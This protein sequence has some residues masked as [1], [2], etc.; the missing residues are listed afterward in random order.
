[1][2]VAWRTILVLGV[3]LVACACAANTGKGGLLRRSAKAQNLLVGDTQPALVGE[4]KVPA[5][6]S[7][8]DSLSSY[9]STEKVAEDDVIEHIEQAGRAKRSAEE[10]A[11]RIERARQAML[12]R[13]R[14][15]L[16][17]KRWLKENAAK[18]AASTRERRLK[19]GEKHHRKMDKEH[20]QR[21]VDSTPDK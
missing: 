16:E 19:E 9:S 10:A 11:A 12:R 13:S 15:K 3:A 18:K 4:R 20:P 8:D 7:S 1:M 17:K 5:S 14:A 6:V 2:V 21:Y